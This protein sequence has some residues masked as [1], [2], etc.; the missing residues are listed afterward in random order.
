[1]I[2]LSATVVFLVSMLFAPQRGIAAQGFELLRLRQRTARE[3]LLRSLYEISEPALPERP[4]VPIDALRGE[5]AWTTRQARRLLGWARQA[6]YIEPTGEGPRLTERGLEKAAAITRAHRIWELFLIQGANI[7]S[8]HV[9]RDADSIE[10]YLPA[11][12]VDD[13]EEMLAR[14]GRLPG[15]TGQ[16][17]ESPH[18]LP[19]QASA[20]TAAADLQPP[21]RDRSGQGVS[22]A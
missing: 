19:S 2:V 18:E 8:D 6:G 4:V 16:L 15:R 14:Q 10:H 7:A 5:R 1:L 21:P 22:D 12:M 17:P 13:L 20:P 9:D 3:N 11:D